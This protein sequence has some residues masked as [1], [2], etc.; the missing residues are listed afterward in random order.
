MAV[1]KGK[2]SYPRQLEP[3]SKSVIKEILTAEPKKRL[4]RLED[5]KKHPFFRVNW[6]DVLAR[7]LIPPFVP[8]VEKVGDDR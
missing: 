6:D 3:L 2:V 8:K 7:R 5:F 1:L 4:C